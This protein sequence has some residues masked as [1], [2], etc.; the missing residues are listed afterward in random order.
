MFLTLASL[1]VLVLAPAFTGVEY[2]MF[3]FCSGLMLAGAIYFLWV[4]RGT[5]LLVGSGASGLLLSS[6]ATGAQNTA[7]Q[8]LSEDEDATECLA[9]GSSLGAGRV[10]DVKEIDE[11]SDGGGNDD[12]E[13]KQEA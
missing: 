3:Y 5:G 10:V 2:K 1:V 4:F 11:V 7:N 13:E 6:D 8:T 9:E 12:T